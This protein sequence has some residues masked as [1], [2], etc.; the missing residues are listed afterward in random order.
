MFYTNISDYENFRAT[1][2]DSR[3]CGD[4][5]HLILA[6]VLLCTFTI[7]IINL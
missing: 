6:A 3:K 7:I 5:C 2:D 4:N 1:L